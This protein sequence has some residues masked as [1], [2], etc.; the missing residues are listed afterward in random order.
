[1]ETYSFHKIAFNIWMPEIRLTIK[2]TIRNVMVIFEWHC[3]PP[4]LLFPMELPT[5]APCSDE[6]SIPESQQKNNPLEEEK[7]KVK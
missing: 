1:M 3:I 7:Y 4:S 5:D 6:E 2:D